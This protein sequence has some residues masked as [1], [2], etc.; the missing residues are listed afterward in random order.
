MRNVKIA[1]ARALW[2]RELAALVRAHVK[3]LDFKKNHGL[4]KRGRDLLQ[5]TFS[6]SDAHGVFVPDSGLLERC[7]PLADRAR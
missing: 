4:T 1:P 7:L 2:K 6:F 3:A 5:Q